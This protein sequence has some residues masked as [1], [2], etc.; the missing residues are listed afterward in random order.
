MTNPI[1]L[2]PHLNTDELKKRYYGCRK[3]Q[4]KTRWQ[5]LYL[6]S[7]GMVAA[8]A[9]RRVGR[10]SSWI[11]NLA[12]RY[13][14][15]GAEAVVRRKNPKPSHRS[16]VDEHLGQ[17]LAAALA[18]P[19]PDGGLWTGVKVADW[20]SARTGRKVHRTTGWRQ[21]ERLGFTLQ[22]PRPQNRERASAEE[23]TAFKKT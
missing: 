10:A 6:I 2:V 1:T 3:S 22:M 7:S 13:N 18:G 11:T 5:A 20:I 23:Q 15:R 19:A 12:R 14:E 17:E 21:L 16:S 8:E 4:E 9:A